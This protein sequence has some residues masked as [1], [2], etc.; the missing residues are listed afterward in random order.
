MRCAAAAAV[1][2]WCCPVPVPALAHRPAKTECSLWSLDRDTFNN[3]VKE[4]ARLK[5]EKYENFLKS[6]DIF[7]TMD[8]I[9]IVQFFY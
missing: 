9:Y 6:V 1:R 8:S 5:R 3:I 7:S 4:S 2:W